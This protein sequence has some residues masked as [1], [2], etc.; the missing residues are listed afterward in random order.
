M[1]TRA[2]FFMRF[3]GG[4]ALGCCDGSQSAGGKSAVRVA[5]LLPQ[6]DRPPTIATVLDRIVV[7]AFPAAEIV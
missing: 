7:I 5:L 1:W 2:S 6:W 3:F 4:S